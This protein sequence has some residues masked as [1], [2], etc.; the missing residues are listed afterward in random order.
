ILFAVG[1][2]SR[3]M[4]EPMTKHLKIAKRILCYIKGTVDY[5]IFYST[6]KEFKLVG[7]VDWAGNKDDVRSTSGFLFFLGNNAFTWSSKKQPI[8]TL[9]NCEAEYVA[10]TS[11]IY[12]NLAQK[13]AK[14]ATHG[15]RRCD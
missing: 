4:E 13:Y 3:F 5:G 12:L 14:G 11:S 10:T 7:T 1:L 2:I 15:A 8:V 9:S 6:S